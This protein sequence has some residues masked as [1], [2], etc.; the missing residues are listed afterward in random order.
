MVLQNPLLTTSKHSRSFM[1]KISKINSLMRKRKTQ[2]QWV[3]RW[4]KLM[5]KWL[6]NKKMKLPRRF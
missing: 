2:R 5:R 4:K 3:W 1:H 6:Q